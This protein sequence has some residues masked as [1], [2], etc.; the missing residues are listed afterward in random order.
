MKILEKKYKID[1]SMDQYI[2]AY[3]PCERKSDLGINIPKVFQYAEKIGV[4][5]SKLS[6]KELLA[7]QR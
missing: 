7:S 6:E 1:T 2:K 3:N 5:P 4:H